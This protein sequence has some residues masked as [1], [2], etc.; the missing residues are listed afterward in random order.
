MVT[1]TD[2]RRE[3]RVAF[4]GFVR[5]RGL[6]E[7]ESVEAEIRNLSATGMFVASA[8]VP[9]P[10]AAIFCRV[11]IGNDRRTIKGKVAWATPGSNAETR[12]AGIEFTD[13]SKRDSEVLRYAVDANAAET[14][15]EGP[16]PQ[17]VAMVDSDN[18]GC[19]EVAF[20]GLTA[21]VNAQARITPEGIVLTTKLP[22]LRVGSDVRLSYPTLNG[23]MPAQ[24]RHGRLAAVTLGPTGQDG[25]PRLLVELSVATEEVAAGASPAPVARADFDTE[26][27]GFTLPMPASAFRAPPQASAE[28][29]REAAEWHGGAEEFASPYSAVPFATDLASHISIDMAAAPLPGMTPPQDSSEMNAV[30]WPPALAPLLLASQPASEPTMRVDM[31]NHFDVPVESPSQPSTAY[32]SWHPWKLAI[33]G[34]VA[35]AAAALFWLGGSDLEKSS[36]TVLPAAPPLN[37]G[38]RV[39][40]LPEVPVATP[41]PVQPV[42]AAEPP[43]TVAKTSANW[44]PIGDPTWPFTVVSEGLTT[45]VFIPLQGDQTGALVYDIAKPAGVVARLPHGK[46][47]GTLGKYLGK[48]KVGQAGVAQVWLEQRENGLHARVLLGTIVQSHVAAFEKGGLRVVA[49]RR[50]L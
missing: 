24:T 14:N 40:K 47:T 38:I 20:E 41:Q 34:A 18:L 17:V 8:R 37:E 2:Q 5:L 48:Y 30:A 4:T 28:V 45:T 16:T 9:P 39:E 12:G 23:L 7:E 21:P 27:Q 22:F 44:T 32:G 35:A 13:I 31:S 10:G 15:L 19:V 43:K 25:I 29:A 42:K 26:P 49:K 6:G 3:P 36:P 50:A 46:T 1:Q 33:I 11:I